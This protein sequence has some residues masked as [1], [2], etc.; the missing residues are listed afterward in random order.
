MTKIRYTVL[1]LTIACAAALSA[2]TL[3]VQY[4]DDK[5]RT[6]DLK[7][8]D[9]A[10]FPTVVWFDGGGLVEGSRE[11]CPA[12]TNAVATLSARLLFFKLPLSLRMILC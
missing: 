1:V 10:G 7:C 8:P 9:A 12:F 4:G 5:V 2:R 11:Q 6:A 3:S